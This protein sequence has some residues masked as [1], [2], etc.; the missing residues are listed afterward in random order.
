MPTPSNNGPDRQTPHPYL[1]STCP[2]LDDQNITTDEDQSPRGHTPSSWHP[3][4]SP[5]NY[6]PAPMDEDPEASRSSTMSPPPQTAEAQDHDRGEPEGLAAT[7]ADTEDGQKPTDTDEEMLVGDDISGSGAGDGADRGSGG[8]PVS[9]RGL[10]QDG[11]NSRRTGRRLTAGESRRRS[12]LPDTAST[13]SFEIDHPDGSELTMGGPLWLDDTGLLGMGYEYADARVIPVSPSSYLR[14]GSRFHGTQQSER[15]RY[16]VQVEIKHVDLRESFLCGY[17]K[18]QGQFPISNYYL[19]FF[20][21]CFPL[22]L[23]PNPQIPCDCHFL[24]PS[25]TILSNPPNLCHTPPSPT[26][27]QPSTNRV[28]PQA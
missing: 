19:L 12:Q 20:S 28:A 5:S 9:G 23:R 2:D 13:A 15:Q 14:P 22:L 27:S 8:V 7:P 10:V 1:F 11:V 4:T 6:S 26:C 25:S 16:E 21:S 18:I 3:Q 24:Q 17:L